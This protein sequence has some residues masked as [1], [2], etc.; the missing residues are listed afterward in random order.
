MIISF[1]TQA[2]VSYRVFYRDN[3]NVGNWVLL[4]TVVGDGTVKSVSDPATSAGRFYK[5]VAP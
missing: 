5:I 1:P 3:L 4:T 2:G